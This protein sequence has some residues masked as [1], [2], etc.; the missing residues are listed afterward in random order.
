MNS[1][2]CRSCHL[3][4]AANDDVCRRC[5][6]TLGRTTVVKKLKHGHPG[7]SMR[8]WPLLAV[9]AL[10]YAVYLFSNSGSQ[11]TP[12]LSTQTNK[13]QPANNRPVEAPLS[14]TQYDQQRAGQFGTAV[15]EAPGLSE[16]RRHTDEINKLMPASNTT[17]K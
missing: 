8:V 1:N 5:G 4:N 3:V 17:Q 6:E 15:K 7:R 14:R 16:S 13:P 11:N 9:A 12:N 2:K 10:G